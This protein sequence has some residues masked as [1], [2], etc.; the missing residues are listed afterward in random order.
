VR[1]PSLL[2][3]LFSLTTLTATAATVTELSSPE[4]PCQT[5]RVC[6][7]IG[8]SATLLL[9]DT[10]LPT[11]PQVDG[12]TCEVLAVS[13]D[14]LAPPS[15]DSRGPWVVRI[16][17]ARPGAYSVPLGDGLTAEVQVAPEVP[18]ADVG[19]IFWADYAA[20]G[21]PE[22]WPAHLGAMLSLG[23]NGA[24]V[25]GHGGTDGADIAAQLD[26]ALDLGLLDSRFPTLLAPS[27]T[28]YEDMLALS[29]DMR[30]RANKAHGA[31]RVPM[32]TEQPEHRW[33]E[34]VGL[35]LERPV[36]SQREQ[37]LALKA[38]YR[39]G[40]PG[41]SAA[42][43]AP[44]EIEALRDAIGVLIIRCD[45]WAPGLLPKGAPNRL[46]AYNPYAG[47]GNPGLR[48]YYAGVWTYVNRPQ[49]NVLGPWYPGSIGNDGTRDGI[50]D[51]RILRALGKAAR[52]RQ[53]ESLKAAEA[54]AWLQTLTAGPLQADAEA[55]PVDCAAVR[56][57]AIA[58]LDEL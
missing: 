45:E 5:V 38:I 44:G 58:Y 4:T 47:P 14:Y 19:F 9:Q 51:Y 31:R 17:P 30:S 35:N 32:A 43:I 16:I 49:V 50:T 37:V 8:Q 52:K 3:V 40:L 46:W 57:K 20:F 56:A 1:H 22:G 34:L 26:T 33:P 54:W 53:G 36:A 27:V 10:T 21:P 12:I 2:T 13:D 15:G 18:P 41:K 24:T 28:I 29:R 48:R 7:S 55:S 25:Y 23:C 6:T 42:M 39:R 11:I